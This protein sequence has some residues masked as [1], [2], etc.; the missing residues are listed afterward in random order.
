MGALLLGWLLPA[1]TTMVGSFLV[2]P[3]LELERWL[4]TSEHVIPTYV[5]TRS[6]LQAELDALTEEI[7]LQEIHTAEYAAVLAENETLRQLA[8]AGATSTDIVANVLAQPPFV[9][10]DRLVINQGSRSGVVV[11]APVLVGERVAVGTCLL[12]TSPSPRD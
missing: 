1:A 10:Y 2:Q 5:R 4:R 6:A 7:A 12:Y 3:V 9:P 8:D 11:G